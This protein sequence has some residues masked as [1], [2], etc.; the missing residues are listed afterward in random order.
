MKA[1]KILIY[2]LIG[3]AAIVILFETAIGI[4]QPAG[5]GTMV[6]T[7]TDEDGNSA[8]RV[9]S[10]LDSG[11]KTYAAANHW[12]RA[13]YN[14]A[15]ANPNVDV[16]IDGEKTARVAVPVSG[17]EHDQV[18]TDNP[19]PLLFRFITGFPPRYFVR[20]DPRA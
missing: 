8:D 19:L 7:T 15:L 14:Q 18:D 16:V 13:W 4:A 6:I 20:L 17:A 5:E 2:V 12:P 11:G 1:V 10:K 3:Y 9:L